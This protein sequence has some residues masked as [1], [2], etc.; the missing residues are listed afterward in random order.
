VSGSRTWRGAALARTP[1][2]KRYL[3]DDLFGRNGCE[4][5]GSLQL[6]AQPRPL[7]TP[8][9]WLLAPFLVPVRLELQCRQPVL[10]TAGPARTV[11]ARVADLM[12]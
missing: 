9:F 2:T 3:L 10:I 6:P 8:G 7:L 1:L 4:T 12:Q 11:T 5:G